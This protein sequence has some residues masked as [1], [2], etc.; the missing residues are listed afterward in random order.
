MPL[1]T[2]AE[3]VNCSI[4][5]WWCVHEHG[6]Y[7]ETC[8]GW[9]FAAVG[10]LRQW[11]VSSKVAL[12]DALLAWLRSAWTFDQQARDSQAF[13]K[14]LAD[15]LRAAG[16]P[17]EVRHLGGR[18]RIGPRGIDLY[19]IREQ[20]PWLLQVNRQLA[21]AVVP[22]GMVTQV[23][24]AALR[25]DRCT[26]LVLSGDAKFLRPI[27][28]ELHL[29]PEEPYCVGISAPQEALAL[30]PELRSPRRKT[31]ID[32]LADLLAWEHPWRLPEL[33]ARE[34]RRA[35]SNRSAPRSRI[36]PRRFSA[37]RSQH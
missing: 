10:I 27:S 3:L 36:I 16:A 19:L 5:G 29:K 2:D 18:G 1:R 9:D 25:G 13:A 33:Y 30:L 15:I 17:G 12:L 26:G 22:L 32:A 35:A 8:G 28:A 31:F 37:R 34:I 24:G 23:H 6:I 4:C 21:D 7:G 14:T 11:E 20:E